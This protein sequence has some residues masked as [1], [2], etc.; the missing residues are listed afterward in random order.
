MKNSLLNPVKQIFSVLA[1]SFTLVSCN[2][3]KENEEPKAVAG[4]TETEFSM[5]DSIKVDAR[6]KDSHANLYNE[7]DGETY[8][9]TSKNK[10]EVFFV[11]E[12]NE[13]IILFED[14]SK[15][16]EQAWFALTLKNRTVNQLP[17]TFAAKDANIVCVENG[18]SFADGSRALSP[19]CDVILDGTISLHYDKAT[20]VISGSIAKL[21]YGLEYYVPTYSFPNWEVGN[22]YKSSGS[23]RNINVTFKNIKRKK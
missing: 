19:G 10:T 16:K 6:Y 3:D 23:S 7:M 8:K 14:T 12:G 17:A 1:L 13:V 2:E 15:V 11:E 4:P 18:Q 22:I 9:V 20:D 5:V 21:K